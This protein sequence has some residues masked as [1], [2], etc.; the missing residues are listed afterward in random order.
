MAEVYLIFE[1]TTRRFIAPVGL[2]WA[3]YWLNPNDE[4]DEKERKKFE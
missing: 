2:N 4:K 3:V 1:N